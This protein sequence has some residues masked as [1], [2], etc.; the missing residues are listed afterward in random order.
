[1]AEV[2]QSHLK[3]DKKIVEI[4]SK[5]T[6]QKSFSAAIRELVSNAYDADS[7]SVEIKF[8]KSFSYIE[9]RDDGNGMTKPEFDKYLTIGATKQ[10]T[11]FTRK[12]RRKRVGQFGIGFLSIFP[13]CETLEIV[14]TTENSNDVLKATIP[15]SQ[16]FKNENIKKKSTDDTVTYVDKIPIDGTI[17]VNPKEKLRHYTIIKLVNPTKLVK[18][19]FSKPNT[20]KTASILYYNPVDRFKWELQEDLPISLNPEKS[21]YHKKYKYEE[22]IGLKVLLN[23]KELYRNDY[24]PQVIDE[25]KAQFGDITCKYILTTNYAS[26]K[27]LEARGIKFRV[28]NVGIG[29]RTDFELKRDRGFSR[30]HWIT[31]EIFFSEEIKEHLSITRDYFIT[32]S[33][34]DKIFEFFANKLREKANL[35]ETIAVAEKAMEKVDNIRSDATKPKSDVISANLKKLETKGYTIIETNDE[36]KT[37][38]NVD[39]ERKVVYVPK[40]IKESKELLR[41]SGKKVEIVYQKWDADDPEP[42]CK[43]ISATKVAIN[44]DYPLFRSKSYGNVFK[45]LHVLFLLISEET[46]SSSQFYRKL[47]RSI[48]TDFDE[49]I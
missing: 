9:I 8:D 41:L 42:A 15:A 25:G 49:L 17:T 27:P 47:N 3:V 32:N 12:Y 14:T 21:K 19:Y 18:Q 36:K 13:F 40:A 23:G 1:M 31:G 39:K 26:V 34:I 33:V 7:L 38:I 5:S 20:N 16:Y 6:Y 4:L 29:P 44:Q 35:I 22:P 24:L 30:L 10:E 11:Q 46:N 28:N 48:L 37:K 2:F 43:R 45:K